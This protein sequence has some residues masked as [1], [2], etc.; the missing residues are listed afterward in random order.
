MLCR[1]FSCQVWHG[2]RRCYRLYILF[3]FCAVH[4]QL[5]HVCWA[6]VVSC[7]VASFLQLS[8]T[9][10]SAMLC[11]VGAEKLHTYQIAQDVT[12]CASIVTSYML[13]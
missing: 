4:A 7:T 12:K 5:E 8:A 1:L 11:K 9:M 13:L 6:P 3:G 2:D 10:R